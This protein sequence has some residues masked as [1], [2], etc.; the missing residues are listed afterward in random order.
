MI[1]E[2]IRQAISAMHGKGMKIR[3]I[4]RSLGIARNTVR[5]VLQGNEQVEPEKTSSFDE[6]HPLIAE[7]YHTCG[8]NVVRVQEMLKDQGLE[9]PYS[10]LTRVIR[11]MGLRQPQKVKAGSYSFAPGEEMQHD[12]SP[13]KVSLNGKTVSAQCAGLVLVYSRRL[14]IRY[15]PCFTRFEA[16]VFLLEGFQFMD[17]T[18]ERVVIDNTSVIVARGS[19]PSAEI[20]PEMESFGRLFGT[21][22]LPHRIGH[23]DRK[24]RIERP[25]SYV[26][27]NF[28]AGRVF[29]DWADLNTQALSWC[30]GV[31]NAKPKR[32]LGMAPEQAYVMEK[33]HLRPL[34]PYIPPIFQTIHRIV[35]VE[36][37]VNVDTNRYSV[38]ERLIGKRVEIQKHWERIVVVFENK[39]VAEHPRTIDKRDSRSVQPGHHSL[40]SRQNAHR[41]PS[42]EESALLGESEVLDRYVGELRKRSS[43]R[44]IQRLRRLLNLK[45]DYPPEAFFAAITKALEY[46]LYDLNRLEKLIIDHVAGDFFRLVQEDDQ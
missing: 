18:C 21:I 42:S 7:T 8:G 13:H 10:T 1:C 15:Y 45:R 9:I 37:F 44:G 46:G 11:D 4:S 2:E 38:P 5:Q 22:F 25:F 39:R 28:L 12:T 40:V 24:A 29:R 6:E 27:N 43:G 26:E 31:A 35:D 41:G 20:N 33:P 32:S 17:G 16:R 14:F 30:N 23:P 3:A 19:G 34:P 36:G